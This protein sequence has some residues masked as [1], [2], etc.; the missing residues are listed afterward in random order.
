MNLYMNMFTCAGMV[1]SLMGAQM[2]RMPITI[3][4]MPRSQPFRPQLPIVG[5]GR[6]GQAVSLQVNTSLGSSVSLAPTLPLQS[7]PSL[8]P[9]ANIRPSTPVSTT[10]LQSAHPTLLSMSMGMMLPTTPI[11]AQTQNAIGKNAGAPAFN[12]TSSPTLK[13]ISSSAHSQIAS[14]A[15]NQLSST[16]P[17][18]F[19]LQSQP[20]SPVPKSPTVP[21]S[22]PSIGKLPLPPTPPQQFVAV[23]GR[24]C[25]LAFTVGS[26]PSTSTV[27]VSLAG[28]ATP[29][30][31][32][33]I[34][35]S[36]TSL[37]P[38]VSKPG[39]NLAPATLAAR[40]TLVATPMNV[41]IAGGQTVTV[42][43]Q[44]SLPMGS[45]LQGGPVQGPLLIAGSPVS[46][47]QAGVSLPQ[48]PPL[49][50]ISTVPASLGMAA[51]ATPATTASLPQT[52]QP[53]PVP[54][55]DRNPAAANKEKEGQATGD[56]QAEGCLLPSSC[57]MP[58][59]FATG[60][61][62]ASTK[63]EQLPN[64][65][66]TQEAGDFDAINALRW[67]GD[68]GHLP[69]SD[70]KVRCASIFVF[71]YFS[72]PFRWILSHDVTTIQL[73][74]ATKLLFFNDFFFSLKAP[75]PQCAEKKLFWL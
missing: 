11:P 15:P 10:P 3:N 49:L 9:Q 74:M 41:S 56:K 73:K 48:P 18:S 17:G 71:Q 47:S 54:Q 21:S 25:P 27:A 65:G 33:S 58:S 16:M 31:V 35:F 13:Q 72:K 66:V 57:T 40:P 26:R 69:G 45:N 4:V 67:D 62:S 2:T 60:A 75:R 34:P 68:I 8:V 22:Q 51:P 42:L 14:P 28:K 23:G 43:T 38:I 19:P 30:V 64:E 53:S 32:S 6:P 37:V 52:S 46:L 39:G 36:A 5:S 63:T 50:P 29:G 1:Q 61:S 20:P 24:T 59:E 55:F 44:A 7:R 12:K 70:L